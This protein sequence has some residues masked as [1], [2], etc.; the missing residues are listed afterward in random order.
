M[1]TAITLKQWIQTLSSHVYYRKASLHSEAIQFSVL[2][3]SNETV[4]QGMK[5][6]FLI[7]YIHKHL[8]QLPSVGYQP[9]K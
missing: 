1:I 6:Y 7:V 2:Y 4:K 9:M 3:T 5:L 8:F